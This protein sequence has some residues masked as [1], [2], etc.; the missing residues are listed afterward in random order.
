ME[1]AVAK[2]LGLSFVAQAVALATGKI[3]WITIMVVIASASYLVEAVDKHRQ[4]GAPVAAPVIRL[5]AGAT[6]FNLSAGG[7]R[8]LSAL[9]QPGRARNAAEQ[10]RDGLVEVVDLDTELADDRDELL[11]GA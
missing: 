8:S 1:R 3:P 11:Q 7:T 9:Q 2:A 6:S 10:R 4:A 5:H